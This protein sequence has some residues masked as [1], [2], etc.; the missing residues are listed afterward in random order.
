MYLPR[1]VGATTV[2]R[3]TIDKEVSELRN[4]KL[5]GLDIGSAFVKAVQLAKDSDKYRVLG[6]ACTAIESSADDDDAAREARV[7]AAIGECLEAAQIRSQHAVC[8]VN[9]PEVAVRGFSFPSLPADEMEQAVIFEAAQVCPFDIDQ[10]TVDYEVINRKGDRA[11]HKGKANG[12][13]TEQ[14]SNVTGLMVAATNSRIQSKAQHAKRANLN[15]AMV[16][17]DG[18]ALF[19]CFTECEERGSDQSVAIVNIGKSCADL[20]IVSDGPLP[21]TRDLAFGTS[22][23]T[24]HV[25]LA[26]DIDAEVV[27]ETLNHL[28]EPG[29]V[30]PEIRQSLAKSCLTLA[31]EITETYRY[32]MVQEKIAPVEKTYV[33]G[34]G[35]L[36]EGLVGFLDD[37]LPGETCLWNPFE[38]MK[39]QNHTPGYE[40][41][42]NC[43]P[44]LAVA[45]GLAVRSI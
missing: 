34:G 15:C 4:N 43:G 11:K 32:Y 18:L 31:T 5:F 3:M 33:C 1:P 22:A 25:S 28:G 8:G 20:V 21:F 2:S 12:E 45:A 30:A 39:L 23:I 10:S 17:V 42:R 6:A 40:L 44:M 35:A 13:G 38:R 41:V 24:E 19:N 29:E 14:E 7:A 9:G 26:C 36:I 37:C 27:S 16:D